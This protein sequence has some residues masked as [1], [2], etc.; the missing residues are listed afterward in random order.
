M[1]AY[2][3]QFLISLI[4]KNKFLAWISTI[5]PFV[6]DI[7]LLVLD[8]FRGL[9]Q[10]PAKELLCGQAFPIEDIEINDLKVSTHLSKHDFDIQT[11]NL[12]LEQ[13]CLITIFNLSLPL[14]QVTVQFTNPYNSGAFRGVLLDQTWNDTKIHGFL[15]AI[16]DFL[17]THSQ[18]RRVN[19]GKIDMVITDD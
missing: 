13:I 17:Y 5:F 14:T 8:T 6:T 18:L 15:N 9:T 19:G 12:D 2:D 4:K 16:D 3:K 1:V 10:M 11:Y 7:P